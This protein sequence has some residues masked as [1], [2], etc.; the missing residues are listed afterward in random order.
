[1]AR[2]HDGLNHETAGE[3]DAVL[4][5]CR[6]VN[7]EFKVYYEATRRAILGD[8]AAKLHDEVVH[9]RSFRLAYAASRKSI[10][11][12]MRAAE[13]YATPSILGSAHAH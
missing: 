7:P 3:V 11:D 9:T 10:E 5:F 1:M 13:P 6:E 4:D 2:D 12:F 8:E